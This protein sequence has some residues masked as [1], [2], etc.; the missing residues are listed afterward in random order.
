MIMILEILFYWII[1]IK[2]YQI[3]KKKYI[4]IGTFYQAVITGKQILGNLKNN[5]IL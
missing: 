5:F 2:T 3:L 4:R 1:L